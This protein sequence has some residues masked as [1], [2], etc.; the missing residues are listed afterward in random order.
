MCDSCNLCDFIISESKWSRTNNITNKCDWCNCCNFSKN[1][2]ILKK[3]DG[4][5]P[6]DNRPSTD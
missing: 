1:I 3:L 4:V 2:F 6:V 5:G